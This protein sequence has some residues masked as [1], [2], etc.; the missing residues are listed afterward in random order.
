MEPRPGGGPAGGAL[1]ALLLSVLAAALLAVGLH[2][3][4][5]NLAAP[6]R[7]LLAGKLHLPED[8][9]HIERALLHPLGELRL[10]Q[11]QLQLFRGTVHAEEVTVY[12]DPLLA[13]HGQVRLLRLLADSISAELGSSGPLFV[14]RAELQWQAEG[15]SRLKLHGVD[16]PAMAVPLHAD[17]LSAD[18]FGGEPLRLAASGV[19]VGSLGPG[20]LWLSERADGM[21]FR[22]AV[23]GGQAAGRAGSG[24][25]ELDLD[26]SRLA[27]PSLFGPVLDLSTSRAT[28][29]LHLSAQGPE[30]PFL[31]LLSRRE[32]EVQARGRIELTDI[33][34][35]HPLLIAQPL[36]NLT[37]LLEGEAAVSRAAGRARLHTPGLSVL[38]GEARL[39]LTGA[40][41]LQAA[42][43]LMSQYRADLELVLDEIDC[44]R[45]LLSIPRKLL[46]RLEGLGVGGRIGG[47]LQLQVDSRA[48]PELSMST[49]LEVG[50]RVLS[51]PPQADV[52]VLL[53]PRLAI[54]RSG[55]DGKPRRLPL[56]PLAVRE[57]GAPPFQP[58]RELPWPIERVFLVAEDNQFFVHHG[59]DVQMIGRALGTDL[60]EQRTSR[61][62]STISQQLVKNVWLEQDRSLSRKLEE[63]ALTWRMEQVVPK[64]RILEVYLNLVEL[65]SGIYGISMAAQHY[66]RVPSSQLTLDQ[67]AQLA[68]LL[69]A[70]RRGMDAAWSIR[71]HDL[72][73]RL[74]TAPVPREKNPAAAATPR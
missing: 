48:L 59:F 73:R 67:A 25:L 37:L 35:V 69:P 74:P 52:H 8:K 65:G 68:A 39:S 45:L 49:D 46:S 40:V 66:F 44:G 32:G 29:R 42:A 43:P 14:D 38:F 3:S 64:D 62:A 24:R 17:H 22:G 12:F 4:G 31:A 53:D 15:R 71:Y 19:R 34:L 57:E 51:D 7:V 10:S 5:Q 26:L 23:A 6:V 9:V 36:T 60:Q 21:F 54:E 55:E 72:L 47:L 20:E 11:V 30:G 18:F 50:C 61:G 41:E 1:R 27:L 33:S 58:L 2:V 70:P 16:A 63:A 13:M 28:G 56:G